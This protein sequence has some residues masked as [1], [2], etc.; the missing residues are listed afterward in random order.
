MGHSNQVQKGNGNF[1][2]GFSAGKNL[3]N[4]SRPNHENNG[5][6][7][8]E[9]FKSKL[10]PNQ[11]NFGKFGNHLM[12]NNLNHFEKIN[13]KCFNLNNSIQTNQGSDQSEKF[14][15]ITIRRF[16]SVEN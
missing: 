1:G 5:G 3:A 6:H 8:H 13:R 15:F 2:K 12:P 7:F 4:F 10:D 14:A 9:Q 11:V 16:K